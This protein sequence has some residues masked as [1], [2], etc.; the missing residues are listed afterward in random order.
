MWKIQRVSLIIVTSDYKNIYK[1]SCKYIN[2][3]GENEYFM[4]K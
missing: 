4:L 1:Y 3:D 2:V